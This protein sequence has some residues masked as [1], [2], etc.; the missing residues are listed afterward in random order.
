MAAYASTGLHACVVA[1]MPP[2]GTEGGASAPPADLAGEAE[3][4]EMLRKA[5]AREGAIAGSAG[6]NAKLP[7]VTYFTDCAAVHAAAAA[8]PASESIQGASGLPQVGDVGPLNLHRPVYP[9][10]DRPSQPASASSE[11]TGSD[12]PHTGPAV[13]PIWHESQLLGFLKRLAAEHAASQGDGAV[14]GAD[15]EDEATASWYVAGRP[16]HHGTDRL[17]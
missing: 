10:S 7:S 12:A 11:S 14:G 4:W 5:R 9:G 6:P 16:E 2:S 3:C 13:S 8:A 17:A 15:W 1:H